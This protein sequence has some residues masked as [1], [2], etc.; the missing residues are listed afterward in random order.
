MLHE[1]NAQIGDRERVPD[2][3]AVFDQPF[4]DQVVVAISAFRGAVAAEIVG[5]CRRF[6]RGLD[7]LACGACKRVFASA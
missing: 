1:Q 2:D 4:G 7:Q 3:V 5:P 6:G